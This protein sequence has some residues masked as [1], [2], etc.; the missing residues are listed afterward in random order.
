MTGV[1]RLPVVPRPFG[2]ELLSSWMAR[3][4]GRYG[5]EVSELTAWLARQGIGKQRCQIN[6]SDPDQNLL[7][8]WA[9]ACRIDLTRLQRLSLK[10]RYPDSQRDWVLD[11][12]GD[13]A[14]VCLGCFDADFAAGRDSYM[15]LH[16]KLSEHSV[17]PAHREMLR[18]RCPE[19]SGHLRISNQ[20]RNGLMRS[21]CRKCDGL[22]T[23]RGGEA[24]DPSTVEFA[25]GVLDLQRQ[26]GRIVRGEAERRAALEQAIRTLWAPLDRVDAARPV[27]ALWFDQPG[28]HCSFEARAAVGTSSPL[29][30]LPV[31]WRALTLI[32][33]QDLFGAGLVSTTAMPEAARDMFRRAVPV[34]PRRQ[35]PASGIC[36]GKNPNDGAP[37][38]VQRLSKSPVHRSNGNFAGE[39]AD[40]GRVRP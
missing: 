5:L 30:Q 14:S 17:C 19:C 24:V 39:R 33:L 21:F 29:Q 36:K 16:W 25:A 26:A 6:D 15:R 2:D 40:L 4:A 8:L 11:G 20:M 28:W 22:L 35:G 34:R 9:K 31:R 18:D 1:I 10:S 32:I 38:R 12:A 27:L 37:Q 23:G 3:V 13:T 7:R